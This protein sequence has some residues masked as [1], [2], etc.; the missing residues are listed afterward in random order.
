MP[1]LS[2]LPVLPVTPSQPRNATPGR[3]TRVLRLVGWVAAANAVA[4]ALAVAPG[5]ASAEAARGAVRSLVAWCG[6]G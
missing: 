2:P 6:I 1:L 4:V 5:S 3:G